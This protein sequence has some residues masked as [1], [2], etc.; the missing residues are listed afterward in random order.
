MRHALTILIALA[1][2]AVSAAE[3]VAIPM[4]G[5]GDVRW[6]APAAGRTVHRFT[7]ASPELASRFASKLFADYELTPGNRIRPVAGCDAVELGGGGFIVPLVS[8]GSSEVMVATAADERSLDL[9]TGAWL[10]RADLRHPD[11]M[12]KWD[13]NC[14]GMWQAIGDYA[15][16]KVNPSLDAF[17]RW[18]GDQ[19]LNVQINRGGTAVDLAVNGNQTDYLRA[20]FDRHGV[21]YQQVEWLA[22]QPDLYNRNP[23]LAAVP[24]P[25]VATRSHYYGERFLAGNPLRAVQ[26]RN[27]W[28]WLRPTIGDERQ[29]ALL[30][31]DGEIGPFLFDQW[32][33][34]G[35]MVQREFARFLREVRG[36]DL[37]AV[38]R[39]YAGRPGAFRGW[40]DVPLADWRTFY[41][42]NARSLDL[43]GEWRFM[44]DDGKAGLVEG[45]AGTDWDDGDWIRLHYPGDAL[46]FALPRAGGP[47]WMRRTVTVPADATAGR[48]W[49]TVALLCE[50][51]A[52]VYVDGVLVGTLAP[53]VHTAPSIGQFEVGDALRADRRLTV[54]LRL[55]SGDAPVGPVFLTDRPMEDFPT[56]DPL[57]NA[58]RFDHQEF[59]DW[60]I[61]QAM[62]GTLATLRSLDADRPIKVHAY[63]G[64]PWGWKVLARYGAYSHHTGTGPGWMWTEP[65]QYGSTRGLQD[66]AEPGGPMPSLR[67]LKGLWGAQVFMGKNAHDYFMNLQ[68]ITR[69]PA[70]RAFFEAK[71]PAIRA[72]GRA[73]VVLSPV[74]AIRGHLNGRYLGEFARWEVWR[75]GVT[76][77]RGGEMMPL[78]DEVRIREGGLDRYR[79]IIDEGTG[80]WDA[81]MTAALR[82]YAEAGGVLVLNAQSGRHD[83]VS[84]GAVPAEAVAGAAIGDPLPPGAG[85]AMAFTDALRAELPALP[86]TA[87]AWERDREVL[88]RVAPADGATVVATWSDGSP[89]L[90][91]RRTGAGTVYL[92]GAGTY[93]RELTQALAARFGPRTW[94]TSTGTDL[95]RT[96]ESNNGCEDLVMVRGVGGKPATVTWHL[97]HVPRGIHDPVTGRAIPAAIVPAEGGGATVTAELAI[98]DW[99]CAW[100][101]ARREGADGQFRHWLGRQAEI[102]GGTA[103]GVAPAEV[104]LFRHLDLN[105]GWS[106]ARTATWDEAVA[107]AAGDGSQLKP[108]PLILWDAPGTMPGGPCGLYRNEFTLPAGWERDR[109]V[110]SL[111]GQVH[112]SP[113]HGFAGR[114]SI[115][116]NGAEIWAGGKAD[117]LRLDIA[118][119]AKPGRN[120]LE[121]VH[122]GKGLMLGIM[123]ERSPVPDAVQ[124]LAGPWRLVEGLGRESDCVLP[125]AVRGVLAYRDVVVP[126]GRS[127]QEVWLHVAGS[128]GVAIINGRLR[129]WD[130]GNGSTTAPLP[131]IDLDITPDIRW[132]QSNRIVLCPRQAM[133]GWRPSE[134]TVASAQLGFYAPGRWSGTPNRDALTPA[135]QAALARDLGGVRAYPLVQAP[136]A[137]PAAAD[138]RPDPAFAPPE[139]A[140]D[141]AFGGDLPVVDRAPGAV[142][143]TLRGEVEPVSEAGGR[144][145]AIHL[146]NDATRSATIEL[147]RERLRRLFA[148]GRTTLHAWIKPIANDRSGG[149]LF[150]WGSWYAG[151]GIDDDACQASVPNARLDAEAVVRQRRWQ[152]LTLVNDGTAATLYV[153]GMPAAAATWPVPVTGID[154]EG[155]IGSDGNVRG[156]LNARLGAFRIYREAL[157][158]AAVRQ[159]WLRER[160]GFR[161][162]PGDPVDDRFNLA[163]GAD[164]ARD[165]SDIPA[166]IAIG[167]GVTVAEEDGRRH[168]VLDGKASWLLPR[169]HQRSKLFCSPF[170]LQ[171]ELRLAPDATGVVLRRHHLVCLFVD[172]GGDLV[173]DAN[174]GRRDQACRFPGA[175]AGGG[176][177]RIV[178]AY[179]GR[180]VS[181]RVDDRPA[182]VR[183]YPSAV[184]PANSDF[185]LSLFADNTRGPDQKA[186]TVGNLACSLRALRIY[187]GPPGD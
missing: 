41:G 94:A 156:F 4:R 133:D 76:A 146:H 62:G 186:P 57:L 179:D 85:N 37:D 47:L 51:P 79:A 134:Q 131:G 142:P 113:L 152:A 24:N 9:P 96:C 111:R 148:G 110:L 19:H 162:V 163:V 88:H 5:Y 161:A 185:P 120:R 132:G 13:R 29:Q 164:G 130:G 10:H 181:L 16:D 53:R 117:W 42:F 183:D 180:R 187:E 40:E 56:A 68:C 45:W 116:L 115:R 136:I 23:F 119:Q 49:L 35:P 145:R 28:N 99:D 36:L 137:R 80:G 43:A 27:S 97:D 144:I 87:K 18:F 12:D 106:L 153:D 174:I 155:F 91:A 90:A 154:A 74:A 75:H 173:L 63:D 168:L 160:D 114:Q 84:R 147:P 77:E 14:L 182:E 22:N 127:G 15:Q 92:C 89:A 72:M 157:S 112:D 159:L 66:S 48:T 108:A 55:A 64:S 171:A 102:W 128:Y 38:S 86:A 141:L 151:W 149:A 25:A 105:R 140:L 184:F 103:A 135:E 100:L 20:F 121:I 71:M 150:N 2:G 69:D 104:P 177:H 21:R 170:T 123:I 101:A 172:R 122:E 139:P 31:P 81:A 178:L 33:L 44:R 73:N 67:D 61:A 125:G 39:R 17:Y 109:L 46:A 50:K 93:P 34:H 83:F 169:D 107:L 175:L 26:E 30:D 82:A 70:M 58:R 3:P 59:V 1:A 98:E 8:A 129:Y 143:P 176:W 7:L 124:D 138:E 78:L 126:A 60:A 54:A 167:P 165:I 158:A 32:G 65:K 52:Q 6:A 11:W 166:A 95:L 118:A